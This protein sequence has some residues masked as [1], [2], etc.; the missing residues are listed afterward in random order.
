M[1]VVD[2]FITDKKYNVI[3]ADPP[4]AYRQKQMNFQNYDEGKKYENGVNEHYPTMKLDELKALPVNKIGADDCLLYMWA[5][6]PNLDIAIELG[7]SWGF[8]YKTVAFVW[9]KQRTNYGF[10]TLSQCELCLAF[11]KG[12]IP[13]RA[14]TNVRQFLSEKL[15]RHSEKPAKIR[16]R[17][18]AMYGH[19]PRIE[20]FARQQ[21]NE[22]DCW[23]NEVE[24]NDNG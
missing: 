4:W 8:E 13:K 24:E 16:E 6:S 19:L 17:I 15:E 7:K 9:D 14:V 22:W 18:D 10:Y 12:R 23:G 21:A 3:Y 2:I 11:K 5:T 20:L 1:A